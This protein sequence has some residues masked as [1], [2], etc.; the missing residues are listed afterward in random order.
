MKIIEDLEMGQVVA[1]LGNQITVPE[2]HAYYDAK[3][4]ESVD[5]PNIFIRLQCKHLGH[6]APSWWNINT[7]L[8]RQ[9]GLVCFLPNKYAGCGILSVKIIQLNEKSVIAEPLEYIEVAIGHKL[10]LA[11]IGMDAQKAFDYSTANGKTIWHNKT[12]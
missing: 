5:T 9:S 12:K 10:G 2:K 6:G 4:K 11:D 7:N 1:T 8:Y 3:L